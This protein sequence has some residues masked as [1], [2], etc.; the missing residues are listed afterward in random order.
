MKVIEFSE[1]NSTNT[2][3][4]ENY[5]TLPNL[6][7]VK[8]EHQTMGKGRLG[9]TWIDNDDLLFS[10]LI[11]NG[12]SQPLDYSLLIA[13]TLIKVLKS[14][15]PMVKWPNDIL[16]NQK[17]VAGILLE[18]VTKQTIECVII[19]V[20]INVNTKAFPND[21]IIKA[22]SLKNESSEVNKIEL[23]KNILNTFKDEYDRY[24]KH[25]S[26]YLDAIKNHFY[27]QDKE[28]SFIYKEKEHRGIVKGITKTGEI[29]IETAN[30][31]LITLSSGE[32][33]FEQMYNKNRD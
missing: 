25:Q 7:I 16:I 1:I 2:Y 28:V 20:G 32:V 23:F 12:L 33:T 22:T 3:L 4:K 17:K 9:R 10:I 21:L 19:G 5:E 26:D 29:I 15:N 8:A 11:K 14:Y 27:L 6:T 30:N 31:I 13:A 18:A 24:L